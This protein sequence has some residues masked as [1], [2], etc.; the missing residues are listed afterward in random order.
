MDAVVFRD[1]PLAAI[2]RRGPIGERL[3]DLHRVLRL[4]V[5]AV[6]RLAVALADADAGS[7]GGRVRTF[8]GSDLTGPTLAHYEAPLAGAPSLREMAELDR[9]RLV[10]DLAVFDAG[11]HEHTR[12]VRER[13]FRASYTCP[14]RLRGE[15]RGFVFFNSLAV[16]PFD[17]AA[18]GELD[19]FARL[20][21][22]LVL[23]ELE[24]ARTLVAA[25]RSAN[26]MMH[27]RDPETGLHIERM[28]RYAQLIG[29]E[30]ARGGRHPELDD[31]T[32]E[33]LF[34][35]APL[36]DL[37]KLGIPDS[38]LQKAG[39]LTA[40]EYEVMKAHTL[41]GR[42]LIDAIVEL[43]GLGGLEGVEMMREIA[44]YHH[45]TLDG[46][47]YPAGLAG[48]AIPLVA[49]IAAVA[50]VFD[51]LTSARPY[52]RAW[53][54]DEAFAALDALAGGKLDAACVAA[55]RANRSEVERI[56]REFADREPAAG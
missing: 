44:T 13:G 35:F 55:L 52:K 32:L 7:G 56:Q 12:W 21:A 15:R 1:D 24:T 23:D 48:E 2:D 14:L 22:H 41:L 16:D 26:R 31:A 19:L 4:R 5:P 39:H 47:G 9:P 10:R 51:A 30:L 37:G 17:E 18:L 46:R 29:R 28:A 40:E 49:R 34:A 45:E 43:H 54:N 6:D 42:Q 33:R 8:V 53:S 38:L 36:H 3:A 20:A 11:T 50:D 27:R 25:L